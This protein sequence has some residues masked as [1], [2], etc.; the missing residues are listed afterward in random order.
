[1]YEHDG[2]TGQE[3][4]NTTVGADLLNMLMHFIADKTEEMHF[5]PLTI[6]VNCAPTLW[7]CLKFTMTSKVYNQNSPLSIIATAFESSNKVV[8]TL[9]TESGDGVR[10]AF[11]IVPD[12]ML[13]PGTP[14]ND[15]DE[16]LMI[17]TFPTL[18]SEMG[19]QDDLVMSPLLIDKMILPMAPAYRDGQV[20]TALKRIG[21]LLCPIAKTVHIIS[22]MGMN[23]RYTPP[24][25]TP[26]PWTRFKVSGVITLDDPAGAAEGA[27][28]QLKQ[29][30]IDVGEPV[31]TDADGAYVI[32]GITTGVYTLE[33]SLTG[34]TTVE[35]PAFAVNS[36]VS[37][38][39]AELEKV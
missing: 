7:K 29:S 33:I 27:S 37:E 12:P 4:V 8:G 3:P 38:K 2:A 34:Y 32:T 35:I 16:D 22:G 24:E 31:L 9:V 20:R 25:P 18:Q 26:S 15:T 1:M 39:D 36:N 28:V 5:L 13:A 30:G 23:K 19:D 17:M 21:S 14:F 6:R 11:E 10:R